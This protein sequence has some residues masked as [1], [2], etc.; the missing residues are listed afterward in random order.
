MLDLS[1]VTLLIVA[2]RGHEMS[3]IAVADCLQRAAFGGVLIY[4]ND[5]SRVGPFNGARYVS[6]PDWP[7]KV[8]AGR[9]YYS[10]AMAKVETPFALLIEW[11]G[12]IFDPAKWRADFFEYDYIGAPWVTGDNLKVGNG[13]FT[14]MSKRLGDF[15]YA[16]RTQFPCV[17]DWDL[18]RTQRQ[19]LEQAGGFKWAPADIAA[20]FA[21]ELGPR[22]LN[23]FGYHGT[24]NWPALMQRDDLIVRARAMTDDSYLLTKIEPLVRRAP[25][26][27]QEIGD[28]AWKKYSAR[29]K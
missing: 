8:E 16:H 13:G 18:C 12:G 4:T 22:S 5:E 21:W 10:E 3:R 27:Q 11:D 25:W 17:T 15:V 20:D 1:K 14:L 28:E 19:K 26:L 23:N 2:T 7:N 9:F 29:R 24:F 6:V